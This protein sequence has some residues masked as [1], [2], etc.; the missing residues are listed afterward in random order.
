MSE[1]SERVL[2]TAQ[3]E[4]DIGT[5]YWEKWQRAESDAEELREEVERL[6]ARIHDLFDQLAKKDAILMEIHSGGGH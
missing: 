3:E 5:G 1:D 2:G 4:F 6:R